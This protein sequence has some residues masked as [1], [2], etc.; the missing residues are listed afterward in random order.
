MSRSW[1]SRRSSLRSIHSATVPIAHS[2]KS[3]QK[4]NFQSGF[5][6][7]NISH[8]TKKIPSRRANRIAAEMRLRPFF[9]RPLLMFPP[10]T[11]ELIK[12][13]KPSEVG[14]IFIAQRV[15]KQRLMSIRIG[16]ESLDGRVRVSEI[17]LKVGDEGLFG[18]LPGCHS[19]SATAPTKWTECDLVCRN[20]VWP[21]LIVHL[22]YENDVIRHCVTSRHSAHFVL[23]WALPFCP[24][25]REPTTTIRFDLPG[26]QRHILDDK[27]ARA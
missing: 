26:T 18:V 12:F 13:W 2:T 5:G 15:V 27:D 22:V 11:L 9:V 14:C 24:S 7:S 23:L 4:G 8:R 25:S 21:R 10:S 20:R 6:P 3:T 19:S 16:K 17:V 1:V